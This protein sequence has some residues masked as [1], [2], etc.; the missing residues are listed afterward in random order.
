VKR[1][2]KKKKKNK[3]QS[4]YLGT[5]KLEAIAAEEQLEAVAHLLAGEL[6]VL[7]LVD[8]AANNNVSAKTACLEERK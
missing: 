1:F 3:K 4:T 6:A 5:S 8:N 7:V 2:A